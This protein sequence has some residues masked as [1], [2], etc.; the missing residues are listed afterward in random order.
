MKKGR[1]P[2]PITDK[3][4]YPARFDRVRYEKLKSLAN[5]AELS[6]N[7]VLNQLVQKAIEEAG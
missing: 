7:A 5:N 6:V 3:C 1:P 2:K 4:H